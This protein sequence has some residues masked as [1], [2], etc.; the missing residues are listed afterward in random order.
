M[1]ASRCLKSTKGGRRCCE[2]SPVCSLS[3]AGTFLGWLYVWVWHAAMVLPT[4][5]LT[6]TLQVYQQGDGQQEIQ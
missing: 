2:Q 5:L 3:C 6:S 1:E 4:Q